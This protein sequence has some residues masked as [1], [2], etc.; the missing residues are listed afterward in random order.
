VTESYDAATAAAL[1]AEI[2]REELFVTI[3]FPGYIFAVSSLIRDI[4]VAGQLFT[5][6]GRLGTISAVVENADITATPIQLTLSGL[7]ANVATA[8]RD[9]THQG[10]IVTIQAGFFD[11]N[12]T[13]IADAGNPVTIFVGYIDTMS[14]NI[15]STL[16]ITVNA[17]SLM[18]LIFR[19]PD[20]LRRMP[21]TQEA[22]FPG[23][24][25]LEFAPR[26]QE[27]VPWGVP[28]KL[29]AAAPVPAAAPN[30]RF[31]RGL[32]NA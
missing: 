4:T 12:G 3:N 7:D 28:N 21:S 11:A 13:L 31:V 8:L 14:M 17:D 16:S 27:S 20:G 2:Y 25:G 5:G 24:I 29:Q 10:S 22:I 30:S 26:L 9:F 1:Q 6:V 23:D 15:G 19:A 32:P 18:R